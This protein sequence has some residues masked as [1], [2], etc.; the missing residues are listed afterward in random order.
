M[1]VLNLENSL[2]P[3]D[4]VYGVFFLWILGTDCGWECMV[5][6]PKIDRSRMDGWRFLFLVL[7]SAITKIDS[8]W[9]KIPSN[10]KNASLPTSPPEEVLRNA[11]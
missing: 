8:R 3:T 5:S 6:G 10:S 2:I 11:Q 1:P 7:D 9:Q 4:V